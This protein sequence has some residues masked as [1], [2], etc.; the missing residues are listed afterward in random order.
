M[1]K[2]I[3]VWLVLLGWSV[4]AHA[5]GFYSTL[6]VSCNTDEAARLVLKEQYKESVVWAGVSDSSKLIKLWVNKETGTWSVSVST[7]DKQTCIIAAGEGW[8]FL[9]Y[10]PG[11]GL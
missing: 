7:K 10:E 11:T 3:L 6:K 8:N 5:Q 4:G 1:V 9:E 2:I